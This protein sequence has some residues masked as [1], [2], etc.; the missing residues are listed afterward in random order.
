MI[1]ILITSITQQNSPRNRHFVFTLNKTL[2]NRKLDRY[3]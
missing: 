3:K 1:L 2:V